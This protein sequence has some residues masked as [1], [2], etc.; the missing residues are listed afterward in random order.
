M[1]DLFR[2]LDM[3]DDMFDDDAARDAALDYEDDTA[4]GFCGD[5]CR[6]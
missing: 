5:C 4:M 3:S 1:F 6:K 2:D